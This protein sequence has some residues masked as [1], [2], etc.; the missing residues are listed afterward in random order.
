MLWVDHLNGRYRL[1]LG[2]SFGNYLD[3]G[4]TPAVG[5]W[6]HV[7]A[8]YDG[9]T[10]RIY[11]DGVQ[12]ASTTF[13]A[14]VGDSDTWRIG[15][16]GSPSAGFFDGLVD[17]VRIY[18]RA[19]SASE[20]QLDM[21]SR[22]QPEKIPPTVTAKTPAN[23]AIG[24]NVG[25]SPTATFSEAMTASSISTSTFLLKD[26]SGTSVPT[27][28]TY[29]AS[30]YVATVTPQSALKYGASYVLTVKGGTSGVKDLAGNPLAADVSWSFTTEAS[31]PPILVVG[32][33]TNPFTM[34][35]TE[36]LRA[37]GLNAFTTVDVSFLSPVLLSGF[38]VVLLGEVALNAS[39]VTTLTGWVNGGGNLIAMRPD[40]DLTGL[41]GLTSVS[42]T[43]SNA[44]LDVDETTGPGAGIVGNTIQY[45]GPADR[46]SLNGAIAVATI[47]SN[48]ST[49]TTYPAVALRSVGTGGG[50]AAAFTYDL[51]RSVVYTRQGN[52]AWASQERDGIP[53]LR[54]DDMFY[55][56]KIGDVR[57][58][59]VDTS[60]IAIPQADEQQRLLVNL[61]TLMERD[62]LPLPHFWYL[63]RGEKAVV[64]LSGDDHSPG[65]T[66]GGTASNFDRMKALSASGCVV[67]N[68]E[69]V[70]ATSYI[71]PGS[72]ITNAQAAG[73]AADGFEIALHPLV[74]S[75]PTGTMTEAQLGAIFD[76]Q[77]AQWQATYTSLP[78]PATSRTHCVYWPDWATNAKV[79]AARGIRLDANY[80]HYPGSW[81]GTKNGLMNGGGFPMR[82]ANADGSL[83]DTYQQNTN[84]TDESTQ[85]FSGAISSLLD[86]ALGPQ[87]YYG[88]FGTNIHT[89]YPA[90]QPGFEAIIAAAQARGVPLIS[91]R[92]LLQ[93][94]D[95]RN[96]ST[97]RGLSWDAGT[98]TFEL[99]VGAGAG[100]LETLLPTAGPT[101]SLSALTCG[102]SAVPYTVEVVKGVQYARF[103][104]LNGTCRATYS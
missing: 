3:S 37:E 38:D 5:Q 17:N 69:C 93:W 56:A 83:I 96:S 90:P 31:P 40:K 61:I 104:A 75:C 86:N 70:R 19:L 12:T 49:P 35:L 10:A 89:D 24:V 9:A 1:A 4:R 84:I 63:P 81:I 36:I 103:S 91:N 33:T 32:S 8:T 79:E 45:H 51:A 92:Q 80:Y 65:Q 55:G 16:Y 29:N 76:A 85:D 102:G 68:W 74:S 21:A 13:T 25:A 18:D 94:V 48:A 100:G 99:S 39:Q 57:S 64:V 15:A 54:P 30:T 23:G 53:G 44:Y 47:Y 28:V 6:Q 98:L 2:G 34:Y 46:Y 14:N 95:G 41:L 20:V 59:W 73:Y 43:T 58:D 22:I 82:F 50:Q 42:G 7:A 88:A 101:G 97:I 67:A 60:K 72:V 27:K 66:P 87:G 52:P 77:L 71:Y 62:K 11:I 26:A 78:A